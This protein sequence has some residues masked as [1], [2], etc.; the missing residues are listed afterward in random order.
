MEQKNTDNISREVTG[1][2]LTSIDHMHKAAPKMYN[3]LKRILYAH[4]TKNNG[5]AMGEAILC[6]MFEQ[7]AREAIREAEGK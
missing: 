6:E 7:L 1:E 2:S 4:E 5:A 3:I